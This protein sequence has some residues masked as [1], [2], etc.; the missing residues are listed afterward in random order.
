M[1]VPPPDPE[2]TGVPVGAHPAAA[3]AKMNIG[4]KPRDNRIFTPLD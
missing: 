4:G 3:K 2:A 1:D